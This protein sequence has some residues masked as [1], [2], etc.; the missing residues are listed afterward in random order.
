[1]NSVIQHLLPRYRLKTLFIATTVLCVVMG[2][3]SVVG[4]R[5]PL[6]LI[7]LMLCLMAVADCLLL[8]NPFDTRFRL[9]YGLRTVFFVTTVS[10]IIL[11]LASFEAGRLI[12]GLGLLFIAP[13]GL[14]Y[15]LV[16]VASWILGTPGERQ[17]KQAMRHTDSH[18]RHG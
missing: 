2:L 10:C 12:L 14:L 17:C 6:A 16:A 3:A 1:M 7:L 15:L 8:M 5:G 4:G 18:E 13:I 9:R 11:A